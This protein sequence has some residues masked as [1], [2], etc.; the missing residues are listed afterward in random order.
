MT[1][2]RVAVELV[3]ALVL[4]Y[5]ICRWLDLP[6]LSGGKGGLFGD[7]PIIVF[8]LV[9]IPEGIRLARRGEFTK[10]KDDDFTNLR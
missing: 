7:G 5:F 6:L 2:V 4:T 8:V 10:K 1:V 3:V 9:M